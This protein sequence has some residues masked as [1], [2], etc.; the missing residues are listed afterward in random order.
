MTFISDI[1]GMI[2]GFLGASEGDKRVATGAEYVNSQANPSWGKYKYAQ[3]YVSLA[4]ATESLRQY[5]GD[6]T[7]YNNIYGFEGNENPVVA[8]TNDNLANK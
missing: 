4:R 6:S 8:F 3:R 2:E 1:L 7:A 5:A